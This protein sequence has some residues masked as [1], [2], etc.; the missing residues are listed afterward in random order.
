MQF[1]GRLVMLMLV[2]LE[3]LHLLHGRI[4]DPHGLGCIFTVAGFDG[5]SQTQVDDLMNFLRG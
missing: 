2:H 1:L 5:L 3:L 4:A